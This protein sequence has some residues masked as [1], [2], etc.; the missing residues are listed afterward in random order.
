MLI[1]RGFDI[2]ETRFCMHFFFRL[3]F[4]KCSW[5]AW[6]PRILIR[7]LAVLDR[8]FPLGP[9]MDL[10]ILAQLTTE[11]AAPVHSLEGCGKAYSGTAQ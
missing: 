11:R 5:M 3:L 6:R 9:P 1:H 7:G 8:L 4:K 2:I 10:M